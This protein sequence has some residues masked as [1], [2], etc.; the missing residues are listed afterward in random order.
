MMSSIAFPATSRTSP[1]LKCL[2]TGLW[3]FN[4][5]VGFLNSDIK[6]QNKFRQNSM[7]KDCDTLISTNFRLKASFCCPQCFRCSKK[8]TILAF[9]H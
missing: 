1:V 9:G 8:R 2:R 3:H 4:S 6:A 5:G 7:L